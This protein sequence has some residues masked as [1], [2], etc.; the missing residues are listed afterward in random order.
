MFSLQ[1]VIPPWKY[2]HNPLKVQ[3]L[4]EL[5]YAT[6]IKE[7]FP[8][9]DVNLIDLRESESDEP[10]FSIPESDIYFYW[11]MKSAD[12]FDVYDK[13]RILREAY[14]KSIH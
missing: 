5:Y 13:V 3:P 4:W 14:P 8:Q 7:R 9:A 12:A 1:I 10:G 6:L 11:I 2:W